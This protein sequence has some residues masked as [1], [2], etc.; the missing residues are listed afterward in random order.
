MEKETVELKFENI[1]CKME[2]ASPK[3]NQ[4]KKQ[5]NENLLDKSNNTESTNLCFECGNFLASCC[6]LLSKTTM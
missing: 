2:N 6:F 5:L 4:T 3:K 1:Y